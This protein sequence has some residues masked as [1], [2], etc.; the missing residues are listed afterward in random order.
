MEDEIKKNLKRNYIVNV[1]DGAFFGLGFGFAS[2]STVIPL[3]MS[4]MTDSA[5]LIG[6]VMAVHLWAGSSPNW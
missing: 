5:V 4:T 3:F 1:F 6:L 2:F